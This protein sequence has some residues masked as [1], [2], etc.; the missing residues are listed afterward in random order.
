MFFL[1]SEAV[2]QLLFS[3]SLA[4]PM[5]FID[6]LVVQV[7]FTLGLSFEFTGVLVFLLYIMGIFN[8]LRTARPLSVVEMDTLIRQLE[9][10]FVE[11]QARLAEL[12]ELRAVGE[13]P[14]EQ[15]TVDSH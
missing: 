11:T 1:S 10:H 8:G 15:L 12:K 14:H 9:E 13:T 4:V 2:T 6:P 3:V 5:L 7:Y